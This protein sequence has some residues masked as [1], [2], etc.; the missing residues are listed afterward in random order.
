MHPREQQ[1]NVYL[2]EKAKRLYEEYLGDQRQTI[3]HALAQFERVLEGQDPTA[4]RRAQKEFGEF[5]E[6]YDGG[7]LL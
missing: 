2:L 5:L 6:H 4:I 7:W 3:G 1:E